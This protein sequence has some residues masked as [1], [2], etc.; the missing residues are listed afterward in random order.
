MTNA[1]HSRCNLIL[2][3]IALS[4]PLYRS[5]LLHLLVKGEFTHSAMCKAMSNLLRMG[6]G[7]VA[8]DLGPTYY[9]FLKRCLSI[10][11]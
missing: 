4:Y 6:I 7:I 3:C 10:Q 1:S 9:F 8:L 5:I 2:S 11:G